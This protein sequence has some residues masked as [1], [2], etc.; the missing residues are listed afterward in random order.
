MRLFGTNQPGAQLFHYDAVLDY[1]RRTAPERLDALK[2]H[3]A[4]PRSAHRVDEHVQRFRG[5][6][7]G[8]PFAESARD[9]YELVAALPESAERAHLLRYATIVWDHHSSTVA[10]GIDFGAR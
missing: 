1:V 6:H 4:P 5:V 7:P 10:A 3:L 2:A 8:R 9:A